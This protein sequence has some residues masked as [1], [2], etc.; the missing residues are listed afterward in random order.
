MGSSPAG[1]IGEAEHLSARKFEGGMWGFIDTTG[2]FVINP[3]M[4]EAKGFSERV[5][6]L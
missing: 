6:L 3:T 1:R 4:S 5:L 2:K